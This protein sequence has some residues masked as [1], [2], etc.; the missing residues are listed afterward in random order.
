LIAVL[1]RGMIKRMSYDCLCAGIIVADYICR[2]IAAW[3][4]PGGLVLTENL[5]F[6]IGGCAA[7]VAVDLRKLDLA[8]GLSGGV[9]QDAFGSLIADM[10]G[11]TGVDCSRLSRSASRPTSGT[12]I[13]NV[14]G[15][16]R[17]FIH[18]V[19]ANADYDGSAITD[20]V[21]RQ[22]K[23]L[24]LGGYCLMDAM[25]PDRVIELFGRAR[26]QGVVTALDVVLREQ[27]DFWSQIEPVMPFTD[28]FF[29]NNDEAARITGIEAPRD[30]AQRFV[31]AGCQTA[32]VT[33]GATGTVQVGREEALQIAAHPVEAV[34]PTGTGD[35][36][37]AGYLYGRVHG[38]PPE[39]CLA[40][41]AAMGASCV[42]TL[43]ATTG[44]FR[45]AE[46]EQ[47]VAAHPLSVRAV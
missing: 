12:M 8:V 13:V 6:A 46:L 45:A 39:Q 25:T 21:L 4:P 3:P 5:E 35:A 22:T 10:L 1:G 9:G 36:F 7:N 31:D 23:V 17:R 34:D 15:E 32:I 20:E 30:Q 42:G 33:C 44:V 40:Y 19:G 18:C 28:L 11:R 16:D 2:P 41:G 24:Y 47:F 38:H 27:G 14:R 29:P 43:G 26:R 37:V